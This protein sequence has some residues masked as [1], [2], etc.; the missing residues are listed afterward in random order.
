M[1]S[2]RTMALERM[3]YLPRPLARA[4]TR[5][6]QRSTQR[7]WIPIRLQRAWT[8]FAA[9][10]EREPPGIAQTRGQLGGV[11]SVRIEGPAP[12]LERAVL[13]LH[14]GG[15]VVGSA[16]TH[17]RFAAWIAEQAG[18][19]VHLIEYRLAPEH[20]YPAAVDDALAAYRA[21]LSSGLAPDKVAIVGD[22]AGA[23]LAIA[24]SVRLREM[25]EEMPAGI[26]LM[27]AWLD[28]TCSGAS[29]EKNAKRDVGLF[30]DWVVAAA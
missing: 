27:G 1:L 24:L 4:T 13:Y 7:P 8:E 9:R 11:P 30:R 23:G 16:K 10:A 12:D 19:P 26:V 14:G 22:S 5:L 17:G 15:Y 25:G 28:V 29:M 21:L 2:E 6:L 20:P 3:R 18:A